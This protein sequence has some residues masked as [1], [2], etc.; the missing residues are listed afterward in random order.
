MLFSPFS[1]SRKMPEA[2]DDAAPV[3]FPGLTKT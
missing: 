2:N 1:G 3:G